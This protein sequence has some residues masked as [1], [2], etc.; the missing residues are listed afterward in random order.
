MGGA[1]EYHRRHVHVDPQWLDRHH[2]PAGHLPR[3]RAGSAGPGQHLLP[4]VDDHGIPARPG[5][6]GGQPR[7]A[8]RHVRPGEDLQRGLCRLHHRLDPALVRPVPRR[9]RGDVADRLAGAAGRRR[10]H[11]DGELGRDLDRRV[12][13]RP[14]RV[15]ARHQPDRRAWPA[16]S[17]AWW[18][19]ACWP[20]STGARCSGSTCRSAC[21]ARCGP[22]CGSRRWGSGTAPAWTGGATSPSPWAWARSWSASRWASS[23]ITA[24]PWAGPARR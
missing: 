5:R 4:A 3:H 17:S 10:V 9:W 1:D 19:G 23:P 21:S 11:A 20:P 8:R 24:R 7:P 13:G 16:S 6:A 15:R 18:P 14:A 12:A 2:R 22:T